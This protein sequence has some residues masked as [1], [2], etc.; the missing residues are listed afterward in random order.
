MVLVKTSCTCVSAL[1]VKLW[2]CFNALPTVAASLSSSTHSV[3]PFP[4]PVVGPG[5]QIHHGMDVSLCS[6]Y[7]A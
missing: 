4:F 3:R 5:V 6:S 1:M 7:E 2:R